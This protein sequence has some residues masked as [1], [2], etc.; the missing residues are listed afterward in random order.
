MAL[1]RWT[2]ATAATA[3]YPRLSTGEN[4][5]NYQT[6]SFWQE[7][8]AF[9]KLRSLEVGYTLPVQLVKKLSLDKVRFFLNG[10]N[11]FSFDHMDG[12]TDPETMSGYPAIRTMSIGVN[13]QL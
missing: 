7:N 6:S 2:P 8:G 13:V 12:F 10:T 1:E 3:T 9:L 4:Q 11:L 5:N